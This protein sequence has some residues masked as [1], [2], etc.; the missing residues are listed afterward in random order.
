MVVM[1]LVMNNLNNLN[2]ICVKVAIDLITMTMIE[3]N[4]DEETFKKKDKEASGKIK[5]QEMNSTQ[6]D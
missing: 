2:C 6:R 4:T 5:E 3:N 1:H